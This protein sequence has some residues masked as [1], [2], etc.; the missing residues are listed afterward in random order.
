MAD[1]TD[2]SAQAHTDT[3]GKTDATADATKDT[4][5]QGDGKTDA[6]P[7]TKEPAADAT[8][9]ATDGASKEPGSTDGDKPKAPEKYTLAIPKDADTFLDAADLTA[10]EKVA[11]EN[12]WTNEQAQA[13]VDAH[14]DA[15]AEQRTAFRT[16]TEADE[17]YGGD[18]LPETQRLG[19]LAL[20]TLRPAGTAQG[21]AFRSLLV[22]TGYGNHL[23]VVAFFAD[24]GRQMAEDQPARG[25][26]GGDKPKTIA[27]SLYPNQVQD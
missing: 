6:A 1:T 26:V 13:A 17:T 18:K 19:A 23:Q 14:A 15:L 2:T 4:K 20:D 7:D 25:K 11:R 5:V 9:K 24:L 10:F 22:K 27:Q 12:D 3:A 8:K 16:Q 21:D